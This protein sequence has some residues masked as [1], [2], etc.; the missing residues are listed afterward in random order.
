M[1]AL[2]RSVLCV[3]MAFCIPAWGNGFCDGGHIFWGGSDCRQL[4]AAYSWGPGGAV[5][6]DYRDL[7]PSSIL[8]ANDALQFRLSLPDLP[9][10]HEPATAVVFEL[11]VLAPGGEARTLSIGVRRNDDAVALVADWLASEPYWSSADRPLA[12][13]LL[14]EHAERALQSGAIFADV[15]IT[16]LFGWSAVAVDVDGNRI[17]T[18]T[19]SSGLNAGGTLPV[20][21]RSGVISANPL[22]PGLSV[23]FD[24]VFPVPPR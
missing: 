20:R 8:H 3:P 7:D 9:P 5:V 6:A 4:N 24:Y 13:P 15:L 11:A 14:G 12:P 1:R 22:R 17:G 16:P 10:G 23:A 21:L 2:L 18:F 19:M